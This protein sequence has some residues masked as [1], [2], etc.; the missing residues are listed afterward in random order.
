M[1]SNY[2]EIKA[3]IKKQHMSLQVQLNALIFYKTQKPM[4]R[5]PVFNVLEISILIVS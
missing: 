2:D 3:A 1:N 4:L 5:T